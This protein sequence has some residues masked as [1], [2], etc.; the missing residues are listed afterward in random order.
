M[1]SFTTKTIVATIDA[2]FDKVAAD[3]VTSSLIQSGAEFLAGPVGQNSSGGLIVHVPAIG[4][5]VQRRVEIDLEHCIFDVSIAPLDGQ[6]GPPLPFR[7][8]RKGDGV[9]VLCARIR[10]PGILDEGWEQGIVA[11]ERE[12][13]RLK[14]RHQ[15]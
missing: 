1:T 2:L 11:K 13:Q 6:F 4:S 7:L 12:L 5:D 15:V 3:L 9:D 10:F 14:Q 8:L